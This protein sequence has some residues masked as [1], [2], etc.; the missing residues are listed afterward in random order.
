[1]RP[2]RRA[3]KLTTTVDALIGASRDLLAFDR[4]KFDMEKQDEAF[5]TRARPLRKTKKIRVG[6]T[7]KGVRARSYETPVG[8]S[9]KG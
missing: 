8:T 6:K 9:S 2:K 4:E 5:I 7:R 3:K 1:M